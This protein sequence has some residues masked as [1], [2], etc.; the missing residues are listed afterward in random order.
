MSTILKPLFVFKSCS[1][2]NQI[3]SWG[4]GWL[5]FRETTPLRDPGSPRITNGFLI[6]FHHPIL[7]LSLILPMIPETSRELH[8]N[9]R[10]Q[11]RLRSSLSHTC[12]TALNTPCVHKA[13]VC[14]D[15]R[16]A[17]AHRRLTLSPPER[18][19]LG[20]RSDPD[21]IC[22]P[23]PRWLCPR[24]AASEKLPARRLFFKLFT[25]RSC[26]SVGSTCRWWNLSSL[27]S[28]WAFLPSHGCNFHTWLPEDF[29]GYNFSRFHLSVILLCNKMWQ[30]YVLLVL[31]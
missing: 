24:H 29:P 28:W 18:P 15:R 25:H 21:V 19:P 23:A 1:W 12:L 13:C 4:D 26:I 20:C 27:K 9:L 11:S 17:S 10:D 31:F 8:L 6:I 22:R 5:H 3:W 2:P 16:Y 7:C 14:G 30:T